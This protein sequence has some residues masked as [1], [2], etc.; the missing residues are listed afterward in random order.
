M[1]VIKF[2]WKYFAL[3]FICIGLLVLWLNFDKIKESKTAKVKMD[4]FKAVKKGNVEQ[5]DSI[6]MDYIETE[7]KK[8]DEK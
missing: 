7:I 5:V 8:E 4:V 2:N 1:P 3:V 6:I